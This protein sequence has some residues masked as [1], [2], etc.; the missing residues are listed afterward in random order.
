MDIIQI[1]NALSRY[2]E[3]LLW[4]TYLA[5]LVWLSFVTARYEN[6]VWLHFASVFFCFFAVYVICIALGAPFN[7]RALLLSRVPMALS[8][9][10]VIWLLL[11]ASLPIINSAHVILFPADYIADWLAPSFTLSIDS[12]RTGRL[13]FFNL[14]VLSWFVVSLAIIRKRQRIMQLLFIIMLI[15]LFHALVG[16]YSKMIGRHLVEASALDGHWSY[17]RAW[18]V[19]RNHFASFISLSLITSMAYFVR[20]L[21]RGSDKRRLLALLDLLLSPKLF[22]LIAPIVGV[23]AIFAS[24]SRAGVLGLVMAFFIV[25]CFLGFSDSSLGKHWKKITAL[26][27]SFLILFVLFGQDTL[28]RLL[29]GSV[30]IGERLDQW[31]ITWQAIKQAPLAGYGGGNYTAVFQI[32]RGTEELRQV[33]FDQSHNDYLHLWLE[34]GLIGLAL[35]LSLIGVAVA[36]AV[37]AYHRSQSTLVRALLLSGLVVITATLMQSL[38]DF[39]LQIVNIRCYFFVIIALLYVARSLPQQK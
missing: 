19:N 7:K 8:A 23:V 26:F 35:W 9:L 27:G 29:A 37:R 11:Q 17:A 14:F 15:G 12:A 30:S 28:Q 25:Y 31:A 10:T 3:L 16:I 5:M 6:I 4:Y 13:A 2:A 24:Q 36:S 38:V 1:K 18:F 32:F 20:Q 21:I 39:N 33:V 34:Q 22:Y